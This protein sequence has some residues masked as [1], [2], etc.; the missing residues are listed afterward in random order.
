MALYKCLFIIYYYYYYYYYFI[1]I[2]LLPFSWLTAFFCWSSFFPP[3]SSTYFCFVILWPLTVLP[4]L[5]T[6]LSLL[7]SFCC[8]PA[9]S[10]SRQLFLPPTWSLVF[11]VLSSSSTNFWKEKCQR[12]FLVMYFKNNDCLICNFYILLNPFFL[13][14]VIHTWKVLCWQ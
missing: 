9:V 6:F 7:S 13:F 8:V 14:F 11:S 2:T 5:L 4:L 3:L 1:I 10:A 12:Y